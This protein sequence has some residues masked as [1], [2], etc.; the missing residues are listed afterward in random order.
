MSDISNY[1][2]KIPTHN[3]WKLDKE[4]DY[5]NDCDRDLIEIA[6]YIIKWEEDL[7]VTLGLTMEDVHEIKQKESTVFR[8]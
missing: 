5:D 6:K 8:K 4:L 1:E 3:L 7:Q 2:E